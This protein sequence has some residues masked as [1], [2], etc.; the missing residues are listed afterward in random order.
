MG[1]QA[2]VVPLEASKGVSVFQTRKALLEVRGLP[3]PLLVSILR[4]LR[5]GGEA[6]FA[7]ELM[8]PGV[9]RSDALGLGAHQPALAALA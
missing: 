6:A 1:L 3:F 9:D 5:R 2:G 7:R 8:K 4:K